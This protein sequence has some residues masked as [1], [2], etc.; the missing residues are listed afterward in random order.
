[1]KTLE[2]APK[3]YC[4][5]NLT[6][7]FAD[8]AVLFPLMAA[9]AIQTG[10]NGPILLASAGVAYIAAGFFFRVP[11][12]VQ[13][14][15]SV[16]V[17]A[18]ALGASSAEVTCSG[19]IVG[20]CCV[21]LSYCDADRLASLVPRH[22]VHGL[23]IALGIM[24]M[25][26]GVEGGLLNVGTSMKMLFMGLSV[27]MVV[28]SWRSNKPVIGW[29]AIAGIFVGI[30]SSY[31]GVQELAKPAI[32]I[33][34]DSRTILALV[35]PQIALTLA[36][37][38]VGTRDVSLKYFGENARLVTASRLLRSIGIGNIIAAPLGGLPFCHGAGGVTAHVKGGAQSWH[39]NLT[40]GGVLILLSLL[41][42]VM[43]ASIIPSYPKVLIAALLLCT[44]WFH[45]LLAK[46]SWDQP[47]LR[48]ILAAMGLIAL[49]KQDMLWV[50]AVGISCE[51]IRKFV[52]R[53]RQGV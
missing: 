24:L 35:L 9:L 33:S 3:W 17:T 40:A 27:A 39:M 46:I 19:L 42:T 47:N 1:M 5:G 29:M 10:M 49:V 37:S 44:G 7:A 51:T 34:F 36:N 20:L 11:M 6:G 31:K 52:S 50:L 45:L 28:L 22:L 21:A 2:T 53:K 23:Q 8:G 38:V 43:A 18:L 4:I 32:N 15:K 25:T 14:L 13:P 41:S 12:S 26:K 16:V 30:A 48:W